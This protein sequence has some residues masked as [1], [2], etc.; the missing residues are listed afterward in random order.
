MILYRPPGSGAARAVEMGLRVKGVEYEV[1]PGDEVRMGDC[2]GARPCLEFLHRLPG[3]PLLPVHPHE[4]AL[5]RAVAGWIDLELL[6]GQPRLPDAALLAA[7]LWMGR[8][9]LFEDRPTMPDCLLLGALD[10][11][12]STRGG[13]AL[14][15]AAP[16]LEGFYE[17]ERTR[18][19]P[20]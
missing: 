18:W 10:Q 15:D 3:A 11:A 4:R 20:G 19:F 8:A 14:F 1:A 13:Q 6:R 17:R 5:A 12:A 2:S 9:Y 7:D 16:A